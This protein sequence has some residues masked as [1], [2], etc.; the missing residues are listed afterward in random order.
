MWV[1]GETFCLLV[2]CSFCCC[3]PILLRCPQ[4]HWEGYAQSCCRFQ[5]I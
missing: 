2:I 5:R 3:K 1:K 4:S